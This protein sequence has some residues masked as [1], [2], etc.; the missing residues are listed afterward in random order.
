MTR[1]PETRHFR[2]ERVAAGVYAAIAK[3]D[4]FG[5]CN[6]GIVDLGGATVV[7]DSMLTPMA[8]AALARA[9]ERCT[10]RPPAYLVNSHYHGDHIWG[11]CAFVDAHVVGTRRTRE[12]VLERSRGQFR[13]CR[14]TFPEELRKLRSVAGP[15]NRKD[16]RE[17]RGWFRGV[18]A[19]PPP[20]RIVPPEV[21]FT[22]ELVLQGSRRSLHLISYGGGHSP[23]DVFGFLPE[24]RILFSGDLALV[25]YH[26]SVGDG[27]PDAWLRILARMKRLRATTLVPGH[28]A[29]GTGRDLDRSHDYLRD[30][31]Q[32]T[33]RALRRRTPVAELERTPIPT[34]YRS[35]RFSLMFPDNLARAHQL[36]RRGAVR[37]AA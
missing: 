20:L 4:G 13:D 2:V 26:L 5:L 34:K 8:G 3:P 10:G 22:D 15:V 30:L 17:L 36:A 12:V 32:I 23:S 28:G 9:A 33:R 35:W 21:T 29:I 7:F 37:R 24:E 19:V 14:R 1:A 27:W 31:A 6:S 25:G 16:V 11:N 18:L